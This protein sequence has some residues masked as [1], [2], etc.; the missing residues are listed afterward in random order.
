MTT[1]PKLK[2]ST[3]GVAFTDQND[4]YYTAPVYLGASLTKFDVLYDTGSQE[5]AIG[6]MSCTGCLGNM[7]NQAS[8]TLTMTGV[9][10]VIT[11]FDGVKL[12]GTRCKETTCAINNS[13]SCM[14]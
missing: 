6:I 14:T 10:K 7:Y 1:K 9:Q 4:L 8:G 2:L 12:I 13:A 5:L 11:Y 3:S